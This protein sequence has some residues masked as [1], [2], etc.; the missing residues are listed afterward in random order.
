MIQLKPITAFMHFLLAL[1]SAWQHEIKSVKE[2]LCIL[3]GN[4]PDKMVY[5]AQKR[6]IE[7]VGI[8]SCRVYMS[9]PGAEIFQNFAAK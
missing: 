1:Q 2:Q 8:P 6:V 5:K 7:D 3:F 4:R 9:L